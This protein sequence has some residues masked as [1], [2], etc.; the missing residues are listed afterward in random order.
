VSD[1]TGDDQRGAADNK[2]I[3]APVLHQPTSHRNT[4]LHLQEL[5]LDNHNS[6]KPRMKAQSFSFVLLLQFLEYLISSRQ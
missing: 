5:T 4:K 2:K 1:T 6:R 3:M